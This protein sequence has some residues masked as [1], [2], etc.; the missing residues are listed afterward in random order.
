MR[1]GLKAGEQTEK[2]HI[3]LDAR[4]RKTFVHFAR[5]L[6]LTA[7]ITSLALNRE[8]GSYLPPRINT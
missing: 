2:S 6:P 8:T 7:G 5:L 4:G 1:R 3:L